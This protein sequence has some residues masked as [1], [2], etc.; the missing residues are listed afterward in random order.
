[1][2][3][4]K[5]KA[6]WNFPTLV[7]FGSGRIAEL[8]EACRAQGMTR[9]LLVTDSGLAQT[10]M[11][12]SA[13]TA[14]NKVGLT[15]VLFS[16]VQ[17]NPVEQNVTDG[18]KAYRGGR[19]DGVIAFGGGSALDVGKA[20]ALM[21]GQNRSIFDFEDREDWYTRVNTAGMAPVVAIPT[22]AGT[23]SE[24]GRSSVVT[25]P[26]DHLKKIIFHPKMM[27][28]LVIADPDLTIGLPAK[29]TAATGM[30]ALS[31]NLEAYCTTY[32]HPMAD[33]IALNAMKLIK[34]WLPIAV[35]DG[36]NLEARAHMLVAS[37]AGATAFQ[38]G[39]GAMHALSHPCSAVL[40][41][42]HGLTNAVVMPYVL[43]FNR[44]AID[45]KLTAL[46]RFLNL[47]NPSF[48]AVLDWILALR[49][50][51]GIPH[52]LADLG[53]TSGHIPEL[54][55]MAAIDLTAGGNPVKVEQKE[56]AELYRRAIAG[57]IAA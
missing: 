22:T 52:T 11:V 37:M 53:V 3:D 33:G 57:D 10:P 4:M 45:E 44:P 30:D 48:K 28:G 35:K 34:E 51:I 41:T 6:N 50:D 19:H 46:A 20:I 5:L 2:T 31:H 39:L 55:P 38:K 7:R 12:Q 32:Y 14:N 13:L 8:A 26:R 21:V 27:P 54:A 17:G 23:G 47:A 1:M 56:M 40:G 36:K 15:T 18:V 9:P 24:V 43:T 49:K 42:H 25:D 29:I 16:E